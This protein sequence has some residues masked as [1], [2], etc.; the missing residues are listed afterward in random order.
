MARLKVLFLGVA[1]ISLSS[2]NSRVYGS[3]DKV[4]H[5][6][7]THVS[8][9]TA[10]VQS[11]NREPAGVT[12][13][14]LGDG[15]YRWGDWFITRANNGYRVGKTSNDGAVVPDLEAAAKQ[16]GVDASDLKQF[17][18]SAQKLKIYSIHKIDS[19]GGIE[20]ELWGSDKTPYGLRYAPPGN[21]KANDALMEQVS[22]SKTGGSDAFV[23]S[24]IDQWFYFE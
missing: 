22:D 19:A 2:C 14:Y 10:V 6:F 9:Y 23:V 12:F 5:E 18:D 4:R 1:I 3:M 7:L 11:W 13:Y 24:V 15:D 16:V 17:I 20:L 21:Q 8:E